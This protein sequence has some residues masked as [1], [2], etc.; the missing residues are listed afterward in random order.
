MDWSLA[1]VE[2]AADSIRS[3]IDAPPEIGLILGTG[4]GGLGDAVDSPVFISYESIPHFPVSTAPSH[5]GRLVFGTWA[6]RRV[7]ALQGRFH[8]YEGYR[9]RQ[10][11]FP[12]RVMRRLGIGTILVSNAAGGLNPLYRAGDLMVVS[13]HINLTGHNPLVGPNE[14]ALGPRFPDMTEPYARRLQDIALDCALE[15]RIRLHRGVY[16]GVLGPSLETAAETRF[17]RTIGA[18]AVG[19][20]LVMETIAAVHCGMRVLA[21]SVISN[22][23]LPDHYLP[24]P[25]EEIIATAEAAGPELMQL[26]GAVLRSSALFEGGASNGSPGSRLA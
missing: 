18:D 6:G 12:I 11:A 16:V 14:D 3:R 5:Q 4:L 9:P 1:H 17:L 22:V 21:V 20:S 23:N 7:L 19:M 25:V 10:I 8:L 13:D 24:A 15:D 2:E 26:L